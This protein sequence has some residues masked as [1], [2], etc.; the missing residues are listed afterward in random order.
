L[1][2]FDGDGRLNPSEFIL[3][4]IVHNEKNFRQQSCKQFCYSDLLATKIDP[5]FA[6]FDCDQDGYASAENL[7]IG[8]QN[9]KRKEINQ[10]N[11]YK[12]L[13]PSQLNQGYR[14]TSPNDFILKSNEK[15]TG[16]V[17]L[18]E[19][20]KGILLG[21][22]D[23]QTNSNQ[24]INDDSKNLK[25]MRWGAGGTEDVVCQNMLALIP[26]NDNSVAMAGNSAPPKPNLKKR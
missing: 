18:S 2:D 22:W 10:Y 19:F 26:K 6:Y 25:N 14:T 11:M 24:I 20:R 9:I 12:C 21:Y 17:D 3:F 23:R 1:Y 5:L 15:V 13:M 7:W 8:F 4:S 16:F